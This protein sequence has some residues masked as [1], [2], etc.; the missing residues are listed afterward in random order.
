MKQGSQKKKQRPTTKTKPISND[1]HKERKKR[2]SSNKKNASINAKTH[3]IQKQQ[4]AK[5]NRLTKKQ[6]IALKKMQR[7]KLVLELIITIISTLSLISVIAYFIFAIPKVEGYSMTPTINDK[8]RLFVSKWGQVKRFS[9]IYFK[10][11]KKNEVMIRRVIALP[12]EDFFYE[13]GKLYINGE[14]IVERFMSQETQ[15]NEEKNS[16]ITPDFSLQD[17]LQVKRIPKG[18]YVVLGDNRR[19]STDSRYFGL[20]DEKDIIGVV[21]IRLFPIHEMTHF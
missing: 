2:K 13:K 15:S 6:R 8:D 16:N 10:E 7:K 11:P 4:S 14:E 19:Y 3:K 1:N 17:I 5:R 21:T 20:I 18:K 12:G 9:L